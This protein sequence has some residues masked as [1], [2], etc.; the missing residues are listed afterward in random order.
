MLPG[1]GLKVLLSDIVAN[2]GHF[3]CTIHESYHASFR[4]RPEKR[5]EINLIRI[6]Y[7]FLQKN[8]ERVE[9]KGFK[10]NKDNQYWKAMLDRAVKKKTTT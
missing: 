4:L 5:L 2:F 7:I 10:P 8:P 1:E 9:E 6:C 3:V